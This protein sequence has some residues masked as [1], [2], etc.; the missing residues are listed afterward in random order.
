MTEQHDL[1]RHPPSYYA[2]SALPQPAR[3]ALAGSVRA[4]VCVVG[5]GYTGLSAALHLQDAGCRVLLLE[6]ARVG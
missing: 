6:Q 2:A 5:A 3:P 4:D 1:G